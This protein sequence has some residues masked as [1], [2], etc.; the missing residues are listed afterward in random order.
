MTASVTTIRGDFIDF[1]G[2]ALEAQGL[3]PIAG[4]MLGLLIFDG[5]ARSFSEL[6]TE[7]GVSRGSIS[8]NA[9]MLVAKGSIVKENREGDRQDYFRIADES[10]DVML[11]SLRQRMLETATSV[12]GF[13]AALPAEQSARRRLCGMAEFYRAMAEGVSQAAARLTQLR[14]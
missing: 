6:A 12:E 1:M 5:E 4:R 11:E 8:A 9:K 3:S 2:R 10:F 14:C 7:L 13:A